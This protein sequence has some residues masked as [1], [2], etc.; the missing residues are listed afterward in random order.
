MMNS[1]ESSVEVGNPIK[2]T[3]TKSELKF[4]LD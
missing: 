4:I 2:F 1:Q 3:W